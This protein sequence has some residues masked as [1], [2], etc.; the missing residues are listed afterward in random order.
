METKAEL[1]NIRKEIRQVLE[2]LQKKERELEKIAE[3]EYI[4]KQ[5]SHFK[6]F[7]G[8][9]YYGDKTTWSGFQDTIYLIKPI[10][11]FDWTEYNSCRIIKFE[12]R[13]D[14]GKFR[15]L[16]IGEDTNRISNFETHYKELTDELF[17]KVKEL[18][19]TELL[20]SL[21][22]FTAVTPNEV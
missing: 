11:C 22:N 6:Q 2:P 5:K 14:K 4:E 13:F 17:E 10:D 20:N 16:H 1:E 15:S 8:K 9:I 18:A 7:E 19:N 21:L 3:Q 12:M